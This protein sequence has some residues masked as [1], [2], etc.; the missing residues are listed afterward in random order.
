MESLSAKCLSQTA[1]IKLDT[2]CLPERL[3]GDVAKFRLALHSVVE[4]ALT[5]C[6]EGTIDIQVNFSGM[7]PTGQYLIQFDFIFNR[8][9]QFN[10]DPIVRLLNSLSAI[11]F[12]SNSSSQKLRTEELLLK[13]Y[14]DF[15]GL[16]QHFGMG[17]VIFPSLMM[18]LGGTYSISVIPGDNLKTSQ[19]EEVKAPHARD[20]D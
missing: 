2:K 15:F 20:Q 3:L 8:N 1:S 19:N 6:K 17:M 10:E 4:F 11:S 12:N 9:K 7:S 14:D 13:N 5:Y 16:I 18:D